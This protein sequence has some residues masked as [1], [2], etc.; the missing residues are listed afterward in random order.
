MAGCSDGSLLMLSPFN[1]ETKVCVCVLEVTLLNSFQRFPIC[2][3]PIVAAVTLS[4][5]QIAVASESSEVK[6]VEFDAQYE[7]TIKKTIKFGSDQR[8]VCLAASLK[9]SSL[10]VGLIDSISIVQ[11][12]SCQQSVIKVSQNANKSTVIWSMV[13]K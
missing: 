1:Q 7:Y 4:A 13:F 3:S 5:S 2:A 6:L 11:I 12:P 9:L 10:A 8:V